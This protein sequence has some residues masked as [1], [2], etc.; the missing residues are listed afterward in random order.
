MI[1]FFGPPGAGKSVQGQIL[2]IRNGWRWLSTGQLLRDTQDPAIVAMMQTGQL[3]DSETVNKIVSGALEESKSLE[4]VILDGFPRQLSQ[5]QWLVDYKTDHGHEISLVVFL[6]L[7]RDEI[8]KRLALRGRT[9][10]TTESIDERLDIY[11]DEVNPI[12]QYFASQGVKVVNVDGL[13]TVG[14]VHDRIQSELE[15]CD[16]V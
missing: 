3:V 11:S 15:T 9:D 16:L 1:I 5:A 4:H 8:V 10:D 6:T 13:G 12:L 7:P 14:Q 2:A